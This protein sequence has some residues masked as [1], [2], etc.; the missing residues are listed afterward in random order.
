MTPRN[1]WRCAGWALRLAAWSKLTQWGVGAEAA[2]RRTGVR[3][4]DGAWQSDAHGALYFPT[5]RI[6]TRAVGIAEWVDA[7]AVRFAVGSDGVVYAVAT[8]SEGPRWESKG[9]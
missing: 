2:S 1:A 8:A 9:R 7:G 6:S 5:S 4:V 3:P